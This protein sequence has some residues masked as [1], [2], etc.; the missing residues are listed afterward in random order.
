MLTHIVFFK[1]KNNSP[2]EVEKLKDRLMAM[3]GKIPE[4]LYI[5]VGIDVLRSERSYDLALVTKFESLETM[6]AYQVHPEHQKVI[7]YVNTVK[8]STIAVDYVN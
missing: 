3:E 7:E 8:E 1:L 5:E 4:L 6:Q 2:E